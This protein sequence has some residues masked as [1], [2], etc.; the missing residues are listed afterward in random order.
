MQAFIFVNSR[1]LK[2]HGEKTKPSRWDQLDNKGWIKLE[3]S[4]MQFFCHDESDTLEGQIITEFIGPD[5]PHQNT[6]VDK[7]LT[8]ILGTELGNEL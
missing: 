2:R 7:R 5:L 4:Y 6:S 1:I 8:A 3:D